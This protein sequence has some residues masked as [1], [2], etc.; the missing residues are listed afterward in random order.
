MLKKEDYSNILFNYDFLMVEI[1]RESINNTNLR[2]DI[3]KMNTKMTEM[4]NEMDEMG[5]ILIRM[6]NRSNESQYRI[7]NMKECI[8]KIQNLLESLK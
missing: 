4:S 6:N 7:D 8:V 1:K 2:N 5:T 3:E